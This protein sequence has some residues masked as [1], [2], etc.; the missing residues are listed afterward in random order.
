MKKLNVKTSA[1]AIFLP[2]MMVAAGLFLSPPASGQKKNIKKATPQV[3]VEQIVLAMNGNSLYRIVLPSAASEQEQK[4]ARVLQDYLIQITKAALPIVPASKPGCRNEIILGQNERLDA[5]GINV[6][7]NELGADG[8]V[9]KTDSARLIIAGGSDKGTLFGV[10][11]FLEKYFGCR[12]YTPKVKIIPSHDTLIIGKI[13]DKEIPK[14]GYRTIHYKSSWDAEYVDWHKLNH[15]AEGERPAWGSWVHT[16]NQL[17]PPEVYFKDHPE[18]FALRDGKRLP[19]QL[20]LSNPEVVKLVIQNLRREIAKNPSAKY[21]SVSQNDNRQYCMCD[22]C[23]ALDEKEGAHS[24]TMINF[25]N[26]VARE[27]PDHMI[28]TLAYEYTRK[29]PA[30]IRPEKNVNIMLCSIEVRRDV[31]IARTD[32]SMCVSFV[33]DVSDWG[34][35]ASDIIIWDY[36]IQFNNLVSPFPNLQVL[37][38][39]LQFFV[40]NGVTAMFEQGNREVGGEFA[41]LRSY[42]IAKL[43]WNPDANADSIMN[44]FL[45]GY[46]G[47]AGKCVRQYIDEM[48]DALLSSKQPLKIFGSPIMASDSYLTPALIERYMKIFDDAERS[49]VSDPVILERVRIAR[50]P[51]LF[52]IME[53][54]KKNFYGE[55]GVFI[56]SGEKWVVRPEI[57]TMIDPFTDLCLRQGVTRLREWSTTPEAYRSDMYKMFYQGRNEHLAF[58]KKVLLKSPDPETIPAE[59]VTKLTDGIRASN[60]SRSNWFDF[61]GKDL[62][63]VIDLGKLEKIHHIECGFY[64]L[65]AWLSIAPK[66]VEFYISDNGNNYK[67]VGAVDNTLPIDQYDSF[68]KDFMADFKPADARFVRVVAKTLGNTPESHPGAGQPAWMHID[69]IVVE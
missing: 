14:I 9:I 65:A 15:D 18:Y 29:A 54:S 16:F 26:Q 31:P 46:Y 28:S 51:L 64:Q 50:Q 37:Q 68:L 53:Q 58:N 59:E 27:F 34:K 2:V 62:D 38:P 19:T 22:Q 69:E 41:E 35:I 61:Q 1:L 25:V 24:G 56:K 55:N 7:F 57:R 17:V 10:Y 60:D 44:D 12:M 11:A 36:V 67:M 33:R 32:D 20:C 4:A 13:Q 3:A 49:V 63:A 48:K 40:R 66:R 21:W 42:L 43:L 47:A 39:N 52:A 8:F 23:R 45:S 6:N 5:L 30:T